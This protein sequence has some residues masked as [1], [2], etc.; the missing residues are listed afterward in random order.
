MKRIMVAIVITFAVHLLP[1]TLCAQS[2]L[3]VPSGKPVR[4][5][6]KALTNPEAFY[7]L[8]TYQGGSTNY[9]V[10]DLDLLDSAYRIAFSID[11]PNYYTMV[12]ESYGDAN[13]ALGQARVDAVV[14]YFAMRSHAQFPIRVAKNPIHCSCHGDSVETIRY[15]VPTATAVYN[16]ASLPEARQTINKSVS[17]QNSVL[18]TFRNNPDECLGSARGCFMPASDSLV[19][20]YY[21]SLFLA[22]GSVYAIEGTK[23]TCPGNLSIKVEDHLDYKTTVERY[24]LIPHPKHLLVQAGYIVL[25]S[26]YGR[27]IDECEMEQKDSIFIRI[28]VSQEQ[29]D[30]KLKFFAKVKTSRGVEYKAL[31]TRKLPGKGELVLQ[32]PISVDQ[33]D[34]IYLGKRI[35]EKELKSYFYEVDSPT[36]A[37]SFAVGRRFFVAYQVGKHGEYELKKNLRNLFRIIPEQ[38]EEVAKPSD[39]KVIK[40]EEIPD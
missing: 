31:P 19:R 30:A 38:E 6:Q 3:Y 33:F 29:L 22:R 34:T 21:A 11:N 36:E 32:A 20:G 28:P 17:L 9:S 24:Q 23:D 7:L 2:G 1:F 27:G 25:T 26:N 12:V 4:N 40:G 39:K 13:E 16:Y 37:A 14:R 5:M 8:L 10:S 15:E 18:V 35:S